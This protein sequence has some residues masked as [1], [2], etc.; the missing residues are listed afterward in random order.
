MN[1]M[2]KAFAEALRKRGL[3][4][5]KPFAVGTSK[6][7]TF[8]RKGSQARLDMPAAVLSVLRHG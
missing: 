6:R 3:R 1:K 4:T 5:A 2:E 8:Q 7:L